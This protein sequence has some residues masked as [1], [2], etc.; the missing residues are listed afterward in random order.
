VPV[1]EELRSVT[2][3]IIIAPLHKSSSSKGPWTVSVPTYDI[4]NVEILKRWTFGFFFWPVTCVDPQLSYCADA[5]YFT[6]FFVMLPICNILYCTVMRGLLRSSTKCKKCIGVANKLIHTVPCIYDYKVRKAS[7]NLS[8]RLY[9]CSV[10]IWRFA[11]LSIV[12]LVGHVIVICRNSNSRPLR[13]GC[14]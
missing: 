12:M 7:R 5:I 9:R 14:N 6:P 3:E 8:C 11:Q 10:I 13:L 2:A 4:W 1:N